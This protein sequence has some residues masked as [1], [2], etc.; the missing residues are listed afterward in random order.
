MAV[1]GMVRQRT[2]TV[3]VD[4]KDKFPVFDKKSAEAAMHLIGHAKPPLTPAQVASVKAAAARY[5]VK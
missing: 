4:G 3:H 1:P 5:G 2:A